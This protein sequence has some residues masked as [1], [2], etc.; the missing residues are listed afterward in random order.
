MIWSAIPPS[1]LISLLLALLVLDL[2]FQALNFLWKDVISK[3]RGL[4]V[5]MDS[6]LFLTKDV[7][8]IKLIDG[9]DMF[10]CPCYSDGHIWPWP[11]LMGFDMDT[12]NPNEISFE[13]L[14]INGKYAD[15]GS[16]LNTYIENRQPWIN[17]IDRQEIV[18]QDWPILDMNQTLYQLGFPKPYSVDFLPFAFHYKTGSNYAKHCTPEYNEAKTK[19]LLKVLTGKHANQ[20]VTNYGS[21]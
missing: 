13:L 16:E 20:E 6:D 12:I 8:F 5:I 4:V 1:F 10:F 9:Y 2:L 14:K 17:L 15:V 19:A 21:P 11:G 18:K 7:S 3:A